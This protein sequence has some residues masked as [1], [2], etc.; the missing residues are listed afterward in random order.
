M[1]LRRNVTMALCIL[2]ASV[3]LSACTPTT[4]S[5]TRVSADQ[6]WTGFNVV[7]AAEVDPAASL[8]DLVSRSTL[9]VRGSIADLTEGPSDL[10]KLEEGDVS[11]PSTILTIDVSKVVAGTVGDEVRIW[12]SQENPSISRIEALPSTEFLWFLRPSDTLDL[13]HTTTLA[14]V[15]GVDSMG[16]LV[17]FRDRS[18]GETIIPQGVRELSQL[19][20]LVAERAAQ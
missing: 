4:D 9:I 10:Y 3:V 5:S 18:A 2:L 14:G 16:A 1:L 12:L 19:E 7:S 11:K 6:F 8:D 17:T 20:A 15:V 13:F